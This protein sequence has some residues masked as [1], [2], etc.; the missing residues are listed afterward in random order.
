MEKEYKI[1]DLSAHLFWDV[2]KNNLSLDKGSRYIIERVAYLGGLRDW[3]LIRKIYGEEKIK[4]TIMNMR[5]LDEKS[6]HFYSFIYGIPKE[7][8]RC[9]KLRLSGQVPSPF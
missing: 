6:L 9:Y 4:D 3:L 5:Y 7:K 2:D 1:S 8:F